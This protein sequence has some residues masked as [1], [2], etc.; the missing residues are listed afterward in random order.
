MGKNKGRKTLVL[1]GCLKGEPHGYDE[2][3][4][5]ERWKCKQ[6]LLVFHGRPMVFHGV[7]LASKRNVEERINEKEN[8]RLE[9][10]S[11]SSVKT[12][13]IVNVDKHK[14][15]RNNVAN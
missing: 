5:H 4:V 8:V 7:P 6:N 2:G 14:N 12:L 10:M 1:L 13:E 9:G 3:F 11:E 15:K